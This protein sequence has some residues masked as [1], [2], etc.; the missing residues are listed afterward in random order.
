MVR[1]NSALFVWIMVLATVAVS[2][3]QEDVKYVRDVK[4]GKDVMDVREEKLRMRIPMWTD[5]GLHNLKD[6][7]DLDYKLSFL[8]DTYDIVS[9]EKC[10]HK[11]HFD[12]NTV[13][14]SS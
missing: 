2:S 10:L 11:E 14:G 13:S 12:H 3:Y 7:E 6:W 8:M 5:I 9:L 4:D 1:I